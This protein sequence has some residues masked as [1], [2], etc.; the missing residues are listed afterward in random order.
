ME[1]IVAKLRYHPL[2]PVAGPKEPIR[3]ADLNEIA[4]SCGVKVSV[5]EIAG[6][7]RDEQGG[8][9]REDTMSCGLDEITQ[10]VITVSSEDEASFRKAIRAIIDKYRAPRTTYGTWGSTDKGR[11]IVGELSDEDDG[12]S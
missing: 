5:E 4:R 12:W 8:V 6:K 9:L 7:S 10:T 11:L 1:D 3:K 2:G